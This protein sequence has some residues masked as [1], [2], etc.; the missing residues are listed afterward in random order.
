VAGRTGAPLAVGV[1]WLAKV[2][3]VVA[4]VV[5]AIIVAGILLVV[6]DANPTNG[7]ASTVHDAGRW[8]VGPFDGLFSFPSSKVAIAVNWG[9]AAVIYLAIA[10]LIVRL[11]LRPRRYR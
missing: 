5:A 4:G 11:L 9:I 2:V 3:R 1:A 10:A 6:L 8:L 7:V